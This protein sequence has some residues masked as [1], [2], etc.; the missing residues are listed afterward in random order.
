MDALL[1]L[2]RHSLP[3]I[4]PA[5]PAARWRL[6]REGR[7]R[8]YALADRLARYDLDAIVSSPEPK[9]IGTAEIVA[10]QLGLPFESVGG[11]QEHDRSDVVGLD[12]ALFRDAIARLF[13]HPHQLVLGRE[14]AEEARQ[15][16]ATSVGGVLERHP[17]TNV[18]VVTHGTVLSLFVAGV[19]GLD[20]YSVWQRL[21]MPCYVVLSRPG[22]RLIEVVEALD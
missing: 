3:E 12:R 2:I 20:A 18:A 15:R 4:D 19:T 6:S 17:N 10:H 7:T 8:C 11:L 1:V 9:A 16:F 14:T 22:L 5:V 21:G 13:A